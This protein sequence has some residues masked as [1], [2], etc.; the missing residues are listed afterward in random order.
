MDLATFEQEVL[1]DNENVWAIAYISPKCK[2][3]KK[4]KP[5]FE[6][7]TENEQMKGRN[8]KFAYVNV[9]DDS[10]EDLIEKYTPAGE[11][12][13]TP[14]LFMYGK[15]K[16]NPTEHPSADYTY[17]SLNEQVCT[18]TDNNGYSNEGAVAYAEEAVPVASQEQ[19][20]PESGLAP[21]SGEGAGQ[22]EDLSILRLISAA[23]LGGQLD[24]FDD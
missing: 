2:A 19:E 3:C 6:R 13:F 9:N 16:S 15:D 24:G 22:I 5:A 20:L 14:T 12:E 21:I 8:I 1:T 10:R 18:Y 7:L 11:L 17:N 23:A 4:F